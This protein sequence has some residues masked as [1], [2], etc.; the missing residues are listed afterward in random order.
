MEANQV[1]Y[2]II[3][4]I[5]AFVLIVAALGIIFLHRIVYSAV[6]MIVAFLSAAGVFVLLNADF[7]AV[8]QIIIYAVG[9]TIIMIFAIMLTASKLD[10]KLRL[11]FKFRTLVAFVSA[12]LLFLIIILSVTKGLT[13]TSQNSEIF[14]IKEPSQKVI[15]TL[16]TQ[17]TTNIIGK[18]I[19]TDYILPF[20]VL[21]LLLFGTLVG[22]VILAN[23]DSNT[24]VIKEKIETEET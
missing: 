23:K 7:V 15:Q 24:D 1:I 9:I 6:A 21:S 8:S 5:I 14:A 11:A 17:G 16:Q 2:S 22:A 19:L 3:F 18:S 4:Y 13:V 10:T 12:G 20:E